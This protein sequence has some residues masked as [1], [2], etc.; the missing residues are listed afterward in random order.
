M[1]QTGNYITVDDALFKIAGF[2]GDLGFRAAPKGFYVQLI[3]DAFEQ[4]NMDSFFM[5]GNADFDMPSEHLTIQLPKDCFNLRGVY[6]FT[7]DI[8]NIQVSRKVW[9]KRNYYTQGNGYIANRTGQNTNDPYY[10]NDSLTRNGRTKDNTDLI[11]YNNGS[12][13]NNTL[14]YN[15]QNGNLML[16]ASCRG[17]GN[18]V[19]L[20][21]NSTG[22][23]VGEAPIIPSFYKS[24]IEDFATEAALRFRMAN[25]P[26]NAKTF[27][28]MQQMYERRL[29]KDGFNG[30][31]HKAV[32]KAKNMST[33]E[34]SDLKIY[35]GKAA[36][37]TGR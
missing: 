11:H 17:A 16:S 28:A 36:W 22:C 20:H 19:H 23:E 3:A 2:A 29:D 21:Y 37:A 18:K 34:A 12:N 33:A 31:W 35:L 8:C 13:V 26:E 30:S 15:V 14:F 25:E 32:S 7:G 4:L 1:A 6:I 9:H 10:L 5:E 27:M 24:A